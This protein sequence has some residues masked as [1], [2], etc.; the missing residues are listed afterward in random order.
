MPLI[1]L[2]DQSC[3]FNLPDFSRFQAFLKDAP[4]NYVELTYA[5]DDNP[6]WHISLFLGFQVEK[7]RFQLLVFHDIRDR[8]LF[9]AGG[10]RR[11]S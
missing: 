11:E 8:S 1:S 9:M 7:A 10:H 6:P 5:I 3:A 2:I 4:S